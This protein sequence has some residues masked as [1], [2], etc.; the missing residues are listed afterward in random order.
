MTEV[1]KITPMVMPV[2]QPSSETAAFISVVERAMRDPSMDIERVRQFVELRR[3]VRAEE[4]EHAF[5]EAMAAAQ[6]DMGPVRRDASNPQTRS[7][8]ATLTAV[9]N[10]LSPIWTKHGF[11]VSFNTGDAPA[12]N[13]VRVEAIVTCAGHTRTYRIDMPADGKGARGNDVMTRTHATGSAITYGRRYLLLMI[14]NIAIGGEDDDGNMASRTNGHAVSD[15]TITEA[16]ATELRRLLKE[17]GRTEEQFCNFA[18][19]DRIEELPVGRYEAA[20]AKIKSA[21]VAK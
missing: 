19:L 8:Y 14:F 10:A 15:D 2:Q 18:K 16:Q 6:H 3:Q 7:K 21:T 9:Q 17:K 11:G 20:V 12:E 13:M 5:N 4:N 1:A